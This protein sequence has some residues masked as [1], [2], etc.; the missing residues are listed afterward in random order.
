MPEGPWRGHALVG[1]VDIYLEHELDAVKAAATLEQFFKGLEN[2]LTNWSEAEGDAWLRKAVVEYI[3]NR[4]E[5]CISALDRSQVFRPAPEEVAEHGIPWGPGRLA[6]KMRKR[7]GIT[8][9]AVRRGGSSRA[10]TAIVLGDL[11]L[12]MQEFEK[13]KRLLGMLN[14]LPVAMTREDFNPKEGRS[15]R[16]DVLAHFKKLLARDG[17]GKPAIDLATLA[18]QAY[19]RLREAH[20]FR[21]KRD[22]GHA[23]PMFGE[24]LERFARTPWAAEAILQAGMITPQMVSKNVFGWEQ[25]WPC[26]KLSAALYEEVIRRE[27]RG[28]S[29]ANAT[30]FLADEA[31]LFGKYDRAETLLRKLKRRM[32]SAEV[33]RVVEEE[34]AEVKRLRVA[35]PEGEM[36]YLLREQ[37]DPVDRKNQGA[38]DQSAGGREQ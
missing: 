16:F 5:A 21:M 9:A 31:C 33:R 2:K 12:E 4:R 19:A 15:S 6:A 11:Y 28:R 34:L 35:A 29:G 26:E 23:V 22:Y 13:A 27:P 38:D 1:L 10:R 25:P 3:N 17:K 32:P 36:E 7:E 20:T 8:P 24:F 30:C 37:E 14:V 18:Q